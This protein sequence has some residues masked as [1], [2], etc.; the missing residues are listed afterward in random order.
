MKHLNSQNNNNTVVQSA[1]NPMGSSETICQLSSFKN[2]NRKLLWFTSWLAGIIDGDG[3]FD[4]R[5]VN[6]KITLIKYINTFINHHMSFVFFFSFFLFF[7][8]SNLATSSIAPSPP[9]L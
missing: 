4:L 9:P 5:K 7:Y 2:Y 6:N 8:N 1:G 3:N